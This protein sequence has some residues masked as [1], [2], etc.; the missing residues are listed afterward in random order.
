MPMQE[1]DVFELTKMAVLPDY[2]GKGIGQQLLN[3]CILF[4]KKQNFKKLVLYSNTQLE[5]A[6]YIYKKWGFEEISLESTSSYERANIK[7]ELPL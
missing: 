3:Y 6:I 1:K 7:M 5:N 2:R 4:A